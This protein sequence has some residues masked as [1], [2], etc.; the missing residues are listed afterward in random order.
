M[1]TKG[2]DGE[3]R[4]QRGGQMTKEDDGKGADD[5]SEGGR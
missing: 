1:E 2:G 3:G 5:D 4:R